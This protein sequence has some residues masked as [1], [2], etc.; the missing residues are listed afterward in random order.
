MSITVTRDLSQPMGH[1]VHVRTH[2]FAVDGSLA[3]GGAD[4]GPDAHDLYDAAVSAC[5]ALTL[6]WF[7]RRKSIPLTDV[8]IVTERDNS[9]ERKG[10][11]R[12][13]AVLHLAGEISE[14]QRHELLAVAEK[15]PVHKLMTTVTTEI[16]TSLA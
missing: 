7:A 16:T 13:H 10:V 8:R 15:C 9:E 11:Y 5:K 2:E 3:E 4:T 1:T 14:E 12:L 6:V